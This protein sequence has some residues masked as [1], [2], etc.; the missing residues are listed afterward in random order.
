VVQALKKITAKHQ[1]MPELEIL[2]DEGKGLM[3]Q[4]MAQM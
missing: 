4:I 1:E 3:E 2:D